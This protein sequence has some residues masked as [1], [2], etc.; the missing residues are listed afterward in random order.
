MTAKPFS[1]ITFPKRGKAA[2]R[3]THA[4]ARIKGLENHLSVC[5]RIGVER[6]T[7]EA[8]LSGY[9][10]GR[11]PKHGIL[12]I[13]ENQIIFCQ[14]AKFG[15]A[16]TEVFIPRISGVQLSRL[17]KQTLLTIYGSG[18]D[19]QFATRMPPEDITHFMLLLRQRIKGQHEVG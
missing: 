11:P 16:V 1:L 9:C 8:P 6:D 3:T 17:L 2:L 4:S 14:K 13:S 5:E 10:P 18:P 15:D 7:L 12:V 19:F